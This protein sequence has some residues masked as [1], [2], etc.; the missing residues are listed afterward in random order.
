[1]Y[2]W[3]LRLPYSGN[4]SRV[5][6]FT[7]FTVSGQFAK[8]LI[9]KIFIEYGGIIINGRVIILDNIGIMD[10]ASVEPQSRLQGSICPQ[11]LAKPAR[12]H[13][14]L[15]QQSPLCSS[16][17]YSSR[18]REFDLDRCF[19]PT[20]FCRFPQFTE[21]LIAKIQL[22]AICEVF[23][24][25]RFPLYGRWWI[26]WSKLKSWSTCTYSHRLDRS[27]QDRKLMQR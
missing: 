15:D 19:L 24:R 13:G 11:Q 22:S 26:Y 5:K 25:E 23:T 2:I 17:A 7:N 16:L 4:L 9:A 6:T 12:R 1:M 20:H 8:V 3:C 14:S 18:S 27:K 10:V 21:V